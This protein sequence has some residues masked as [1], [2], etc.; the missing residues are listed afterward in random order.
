LQE[1]VKSYRIST[2]FLL[3]ENILK[4]SGESILREWKYVD[5]ATGN[6]AESDHRHL[7]HLMCLYPLNEVTSSSPYFNTVLN[8]LKLRGIQSQGWSM[9]WK[10]N[11]WARTLQGDSCRQIKLMVILVCAQ[12]WQR[13]C[14]RV[15]MPQ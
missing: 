8:S 12:K 9:G 7:S 11:L 4:C 1:S 5:Y 13:C 15:V 14:F 2:L 6:G 10:M 3:K